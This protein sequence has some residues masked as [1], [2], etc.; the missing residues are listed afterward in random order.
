MHADD[1]TFHKLVALAVYDE[2]V[3]GHPYVE[4]GAEDGSGLCFPVV[5]FDYDC[6]IE[7][8]VGLM[9][10]PGAGPERND[11]KR[12]REFHNFPTANATFSAVTCPS[13]TAFVR[14]VM[15]T[16]LPYGTCG[17]L[18]FP[19]IRRILVDADESVLPQ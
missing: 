7:I 6:E 4:I 5:L 13:S 10:A 15:R 19:D 14:V 16:L 2:Q 18:K 17:V 9:G 12:L 3:D 1:G 11:T 8:A